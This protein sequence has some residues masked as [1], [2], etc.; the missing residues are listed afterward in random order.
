MYS[1]A[2]LK[3]Y[4]IF[5]GI[6]CLNYSLNTWSADA[7]DLNKDPQ[8]KPRHKELLTVNINKYKTTCRGFFFSRIHK[9][10]FSLNLFLPLLVYF[11]VESPHLTRGLI[12]ILE[13]V[14]E[15]MQIISREKKIPQ[16]WQKRLWATTEGFSNDV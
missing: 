12:L 5:L 2:I 16:N 6:K 10:Q 8:S 7:A 9:W 1:G 11:N 14:D 3:T 4:M 15:N 13:P